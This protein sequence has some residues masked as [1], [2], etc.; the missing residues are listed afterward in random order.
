MIPFKM[1]DWLQ[2][3][4]VKDFI[5][6]LEKEF[7]TILI[8]GKGRGHQTWV[9]PFL[10]IK[11]ALAMNPVLEVKVYKWI[12]DELIKYRNESGDSYKKMA[13]SLYINLSNKSEFRETLIDYA[14]IIKRECDVS[15]WQTATEEQLKLR[16]KIHDNV[17]MLAD[18]IREKK[19]L[20]EIAIK[21]AK[22][23]K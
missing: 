14:N 22:E 21:K 10:F 19:N 18:I 2:T 7:G 12:Y 20:I 1:S 17:S 11:M 13:G 9:H 4:Q 5:A 16:D 6:E 8:S 15:D 3:K 23:N